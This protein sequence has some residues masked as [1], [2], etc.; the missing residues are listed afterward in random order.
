M[1]DLDQYEGHEKKIQTVSLSLAKKA[2]GLPK[3]IAFFR[4]LD[5]EFKEDL[6]A[7]NAKILGLA[8]KLLDVAHGLDQTKSKAKGKER[9]P[10]GNVD[11]VSDRFG[12]DVVGTLEPLLEK[13]VSSCSFIWY[14]IITRSKGHVSRCI[15][16]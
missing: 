12:S 11:E 3:D 7:C 8:N 14:D 2:F 4:T 15:L 10:L 13:T 9:V 5:S 6:D 1:S 16:E